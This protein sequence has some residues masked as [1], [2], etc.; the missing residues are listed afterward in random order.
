M[1]LGHARLATKDL[2]PSGEQPL[3]NASGTVHVVV[4]G[5]LYRYEAL[6]QDLSSS[7]SFKGTSDSELLLA[8]YERE[9]IR[10]FPYL[11]GEFAI[12]LY[13]SRE[14]I[15]L[16]A[17]D[18]HGVKPLHWTTVDGRLLIA[19]EMKAFLPFGWM[20]KWDVRSIREEGV[21]H[22]ERTM[23]QGVRKF[24]LR[25]LTFV[26]QLLPGSYL[27]CLSFDYMKVQNYWED[28]YPDKDEVEA[29]TP[30]QM[31]TGLRDQMLQSD[32]PVGIYLSGGIDSAAIAGI[33]NDILRMSKTN[34]R[35]LGENSEQDARELMC[36]SVGF[37]TNT[38]FGE[39]AVA[40]RTADFLGL[41]L[42]IK[43]VSEADF[44]DHF[45]A[46]YA[47]GEHNCPDLNHIGKFLLSKRVHEHGIKVVLT[48]EGS[49][50]HYGGYPWLVSEVLREPDTS[51]KQDP[52]SAGQSTARARKLEEKITPGVRGS[53]NYAIASTAL[54]RRL[55]GEVSCRFALTMAPFAEW[56][57][58]RFGQTESIAQARAFAL[59]AKQISNVQ[60]RWHPLHTASQLW[61]RGGL[62]TM[63]LKSQDHMAMAHSVECRPPFLDH[64]LT[65]FANHLPPSLKIKIE[66]D[67]ARGCQALVTQEVYERKK[68]SYLA[69]YKFPAGGPIHKLMQRLL[70]RKKVEGL[71]FVDV[72]KMDQLLKNAFAPDSDGSAMRPLFVVAQWVVIADTLGVAK[73]CPNDG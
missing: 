40:Q 70:T 53:E 33:A 25:R 42:H 73:A 66:M 38:D 71:G 23:F 18:R 63:I 48:G 8:L 56:T 16:V 12:V 39:S 58:T 50:E 72:D 54:P 44:A 4:N 14:Q 61:K 37:D 15:L 11:R 52:V 36:F 1:A 67:T 46:T 5:E 68:Q 6:R 43:I 13:D 60:K 19:S 10:L 21:L 69:P 59:G 32:V 2:S 57:D 31:I 49:D 27:T 7:Y 3:S 51:V 29:R 41:P 35:A 28:E 47:L 26:Y 22:D 20:P 30:D 65:Q 17:R 45:E 34:P 55:L 64:D 62:A 9:G 24:H